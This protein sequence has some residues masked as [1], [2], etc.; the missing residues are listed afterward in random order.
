MP[1]LERGYGASVR[2]AIT[3]LSMGGAGAV[4]YAAR[5]PG[6]FAAAVT[7]QAAL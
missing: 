6:M 3:G 7:R 4:S 5:C 1:L 2:R